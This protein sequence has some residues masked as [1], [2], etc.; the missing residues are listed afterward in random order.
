MWLSSNKFKRF[1][2]EQAAMCGQSE[3]L[4]RYSDYTLSFTGSGKIKIQCPQC[5]EEFATEFSVESRFKILRS[6]KEV[7]KHYDFFNDTKHRSILI[8]LNNCYSC[9]G[10]VTNLLNKFLVL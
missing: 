5:S 6:E 7:R 1:G 3:W 10:C 2:N 4:V 9:N 8:I